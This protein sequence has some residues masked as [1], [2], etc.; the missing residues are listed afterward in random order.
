MKHSVATNPAKNLL[1]ELAG[2]LSL[3]YRW[4]GKDIDS[5]IKEP[6]QR[7]FKNRKSKEIRLFKTC[8]KKLDKEFGKN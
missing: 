7:Y 1:A 6:K 8:D 5:I 4:K 3:P 2:S